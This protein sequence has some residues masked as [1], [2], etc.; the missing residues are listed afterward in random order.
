[1][2]RLK[3]SDAISVLE[4]ELSLAE[5]LAR[6]STVEIDVRQVELELQVEYRTEADTNDTSVVVLTDH[7]N[8]RSAGDTGHRLRLVFDRGDAGTRAA[9]S[10]RDDKQGLPGSTDKG[11]DSDQVLE[12]LDRNVLL[13]RTLDTFPA[14]YLTVIAIIQGVALGI[15]LENVV[16]PAL[17]P[18]HR[19][20]LI[21]Q[22]VAGLSCIIVASYEYL[23]FTT[24]MRWT[25]T[26]LDTLVPY[27]LGVAEIIPA[28]LLSRFTWWWLFM[29]ILMTTGGLAFVHTMYRSSY[30]MFDNSNRSSRRSA[31]DS[32]QI[33]NRLQRLLYMLIGCCAVAAAIGY[34]L[35]FAG[36]RQHSADTLDQRLL[37]WV[38]TGL[39]ILIGV[40]SELQLKAFYNDYGLPRQLRIRHSPSPREPQLTR[41]PTASTGDDAAEA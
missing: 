40:I 14:G 25:P 1:M 38:I 26:F 10:G 20:V 24:I 30:L 27:V 31:P 13:R 29:V 22:G 28:L 32:R 33:Y 8:G 11:A 41:L 34:S 4:A 21:G 35:F 12:K 7:T 9:S 37:P 17:A 2:G 5:K 23:W 16:G 6:H 18:T 36:F 15:W 19:W 3:L 39:A